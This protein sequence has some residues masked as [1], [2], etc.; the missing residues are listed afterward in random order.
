MKEITNLIQ[1]LAFGVCVWS[2]ISP[3]LPRAIIG[4]GLIF[5]TALDTRKEKKE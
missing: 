2:V 4:I 1:V 3:N 5:A